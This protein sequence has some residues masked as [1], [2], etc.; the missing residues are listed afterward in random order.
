MAAA[1]GNSA[2]N[3]SLEAIQ[4]IHGYESLDSAGETAAVYTERAAAVQKNVAQGKGY[5]DSLVVNG[6]FHG[7]VLE[8]HVRGLAGSLDDLKESG[9]IAGL[10]GCGFI[11]RALVVQYE[12]HGAEE[13]AVTADLADSGGLLDELLLCDAAQVCLA[14]DG[15]DSLHFSRN[16]RIGVCQVGVAALGINDAERI[17]LFIEIQIDLLYLGAFGIATTPPTEEAD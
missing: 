15:G 6:A 16:A 11:L 3:S 17:A 8:V 4:H 14:E 7:D 1:F 9:E 10:E 2:V 12:V 5:A 13:S